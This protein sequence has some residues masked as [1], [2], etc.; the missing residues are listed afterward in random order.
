MKSQPQ[1]MRHA[2]KLLI[3]MRRFAS[4]QKRKF[5]HRVINPGR[6]ALEL[7]QIRFSD[8]LSV[9]T[10]RAGSIRMALISD[11]ESYTSE[12]QF[13]PFSFYRSELRSKTGLISARLLLKDVLRAPKLIL[14]RFDIIAIKLYYRTPASEALEAIGTIRTT[15][16]QMRIIYFDGDDDLNIQWP[17]LLREVDKYVK[18]HV[19]RDRENYLRSFVGKSNLHD[20]VHRRYGHAFTEND[21]GYYN[22][23]GVLIRESGQVP[24]DQIAKIA[25]GF[26][27]ALDQPIMR[28]YAAAKRRPDIEKDTD[29]VFRGNVPNDWT[30]YLRDGVE[31]ILKRLSSSYRVITPKSRVSRD[32]YYREMA[33][34]KICVSPFGYGEICWRDFEA[35]LSRCLLIK[36]DMSHVETR[37]NIFIPYETYVPV[38]WDFSDLEEK[39]TFYL[40]NHD[41]R[42]RIVEQAFKVLDDFYQS[43]EFVRSIHELI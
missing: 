6:F 37:P 16:P 5:I 8:R 15:A 25:P 14:S 31:P 13:S 4:L 11:R 43:K 23:K 12:E 28:L 24:K 38:K 41:H 32:K 18:K 3:G 40:E 20:Y 36:P 21:Y 34:T 22:G 19:F 2:T 30:R 39:C 29:V 26:N 33:T 1:T 9:G 42:T 27:L 10:A 17:A 35:V 7:A